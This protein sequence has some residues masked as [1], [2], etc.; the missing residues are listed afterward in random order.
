MYNSANVTAGSLILFCLRTNIERVLDMIEKPK[1]FPIAKVRRWLP[2]FLLVVFIAAMAV[3]AAQFNA[4]ENFWL[5]EYF[6]IEMVNHSWA[7]IPSA[8]AADVHPPLYYYIVKLF[9]SAFGNAHVV[10]RIA[11][12]VSYVLILGMALVFFRRSFG[13][14]AAFL[15]ICL[16]APNVTSLSHFTEAR[17]YGWATFFVLLCGYSAYRLLSDAAPHRRWWITLTISGLCAAYLH[18]FALLAVGFVYLSLLV[19]IVRN[20]R[21][22]LK[23]WAIAAGVSILCYLPWVAVAA[24]HLLQ[25]ATGGFWLQETP[26]LSDTLE[27]IVGS[28][29]S[30]WCI[31]AVL[32]LCCTAYLFCRKEPAAKRWLTGTA[33]VTA[34][35]VPLLGYAASALLHPMYLARYFIPTLG[36]IWLAMGV[37]AAG[38]TAKLP[39]FF[40]LI[41]RALLIA[42]VLFA[43]YEPAV[44]LL[45]EQRETTR[46]VADGVNFVSSRYESGDR[47]YSASEKIDE[48]VLEFFFPNTDTAAGNDPA[49]ALPAANASLFLVFPEQDPGGDWADTMANAGLQ[50]EEWQGTILNN[51]WCRIYYYTPID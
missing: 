10:Y 50:I 36:L 1:S 12:F 6:T 42:A 9:L 8:T 44:D 23:S 26:P 37:S 11:S 35:C 21:S 2:D 51:E 48:R 47:I 43:M 7:E 40:C 29:F 15:F 20:R 3:F 46:I 14:F 16:M 38:L 28:R 39:K 30:S 32:A 34:V 17:M 24:G 19:Y 31:L 27:L 5:D 45:Q 13:G 33:I 25:Q 4:Y 49:A 18:Y 41:S 22:A